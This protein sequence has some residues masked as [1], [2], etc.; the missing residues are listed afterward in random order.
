MFDKPQP[1]GPRVSV[2]KVGYLCPS[3][4]EAHCLWDVISTAR[5]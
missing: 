5:V 1:S 3:G 2:G 4:H